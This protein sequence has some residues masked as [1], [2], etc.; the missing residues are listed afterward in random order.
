MLIKFLKTFACNRKFPSTHSLTVNNSNR[1]VETVGNDS[2]D[3]LV[4]EIF[5]NFL[6]I[7]Y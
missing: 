5:T 2:L 6:Q 4:K 3:F 7:R 1:H